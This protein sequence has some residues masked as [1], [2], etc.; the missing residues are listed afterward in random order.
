MAKRLAR[1]VKSWYPAAPSA[2]KLRYPPN[3]GSV[4]VYFDPQYERYVF[5]SVT[6]NLPQTHIQIS[7]SIL[8]SLYELR[9]IV[10]EAGIQ[11]LSLPKLASCYDKLDF[12][13]VFELIYQV[14]DPLP[15]TI[16]IH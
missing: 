2:I 3:I 4:L 9:E 14:L 7:T 6:K 12:N 1:Q 11:H 10:I 8:A 16:Y 13:I 15:I 5:S